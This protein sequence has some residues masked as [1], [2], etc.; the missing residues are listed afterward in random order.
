MGL[1]WDNTD[2]E[3]KFGLEIKLEGAG[4]MVGNWEY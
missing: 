1:G 3:F 2:W 4:G